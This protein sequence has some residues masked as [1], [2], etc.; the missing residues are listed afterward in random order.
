VSPLIVVINLARRVRFPPLPPHSDDLC[1]D[2]QSGAL[3]WWPARTTRRSGL[4]AIGVRTARGATFCAIRRAR[5]RYGFGSF[6]SG[7]SWISGLRHSHGRLPRS[8]LRFGHSASVLRMRTGGDNC[9]GSEGYD[10]QLHLFCLLE[11]L[12]CQCNS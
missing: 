9:C 11:V 12:H 1:R 4:N 2:A 8:S 3:A 5:T 10:W 6:S 7:R